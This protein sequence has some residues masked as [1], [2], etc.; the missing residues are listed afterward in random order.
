V[1]DEPEVL[2]ALRRALRHEPYEVLCAQDGLEALDLLDRFP[3]NVVV[4]DE[5]MPGMSGSEL[6]AEVRKR[7][8]FL[9][10]IILTGYPGPTLFIRSLEEGGDLLMSKPWDE[11]KLRRTIWQL[12]TNMDPSLGGDPGGKGA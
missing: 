8:P 3:I 10:R 9:G 12:V 1:D 2:S 5:W 6:L 7:W 11:V 4:T